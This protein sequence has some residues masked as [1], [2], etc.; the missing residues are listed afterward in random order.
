MAQGGLYQVDRRAPVK[1]VGG[2]GMAQPVRGNLG[3]YPGPGSGS[4]NDPVHLGG[5]QVT[6]TL[7]GG[8]H[9]GL[10]AGLTL[11]SL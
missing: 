1:G 2:M 3:L 5:V 7:P 10:K 8:E 9:R 6:L 11:D 4:L